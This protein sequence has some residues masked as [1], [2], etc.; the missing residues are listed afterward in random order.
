MPRAKYKYKKSLAERYPPSA[1]CSCEICLGYCAR[2]G[3]WTVEEAG[4]AILAYPQRIMLEMSPDRTFGVLS[5]AFIGCEGGFATNECAP[6]GC[7]FLKDGLCE[8]Y[9]TGVQPLECRFCHHDRPG[10]G[11]KCHADLE[12]DWHTPAGQALV[13]N[14]I[15]LTGF[16]G[17]QNRL[18]WPKPR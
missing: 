16:W 10:L 2:P 1:P 3:W 12:A 15:R 13:E 8:L 4:R 14:W 5:P 9:G 11:P 18:A 6:N 17:R 7:N